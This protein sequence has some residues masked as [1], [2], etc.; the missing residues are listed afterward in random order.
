MIEFSL[1][2]FIKKSEYLHDHLRFAGLCSPAQWKEQTPAVILT[3]RDILAFA[4][5]WNIPETK[6]RCASFLNKL[7]LSIALSFPTPY[8]APAEIISEITGIQD[9]LK[10]EQEKVKFA[11]ITPEKVQY[12]EQEKLF[13]EAV[14]KNFP[15]A[16]DEIK[17][18]GNCLAQGLNDA[19]VF[20]L[21]RTVEYGLRGFAKFLQVSIPAEELEYKDWKVGLDQIRAAAK[22]KTEVGL[23]SDKERAEAR[24]FYNGVLSEFE[25]FKDVWRNSLMHTRNL[26]YKSGEAAAVFERVKTFMERLA[27][28]VSE[29]F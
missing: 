14:F 6:G 12:F 9:S 2:D 8:I 20:H 4:E 10:R 24:E 26:P 22:T 27:V 28:H 23:M 5:T 29:D 1:R 15:S 13:A 17:A 21:M 18:A 16:R 19:A 25:G 7:E 3:I 11:V